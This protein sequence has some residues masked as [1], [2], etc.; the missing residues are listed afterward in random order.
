MVMLEKDN[1]SVQRLYEQDIEYINR[2]LIGQSFADR[3]HTL[4]MFHQN[5]HGKTYDQMITEDLDKAITNKL[6]KLGII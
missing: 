1:I 2:K 6:Q 5:T 3:V 4:T